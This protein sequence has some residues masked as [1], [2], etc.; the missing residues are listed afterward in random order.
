MNTTPDALKEF[1]RLAKAATQGNWARSGVRDKRRMQ[2]EDCIVLL[3][4]DAGVGYF[5][6]GRNG[7]QHHEA[8]NDVAFIAWCFNHRD[9][10]SRALSRPAGGES[11]REKFEAVMRS[12]G[13]TDSTF[14]RDKTGGYLF[15]YMQIRWETWQAARSTASAGDARR[16]EWFS[17]GVSDKMR[18]AAPQAPS[19]ASAGD[20][21]RG[22][23]HIADNL[24]S[25]LGSS[26]TAGG[27]G[28]GM[29]ADHA[30]A[31]QFADIAVAWIENEI[32]KAPATATAPEGWVMVPREPTVDMV[33]RGREQLSQGDAKVQTHARVLW[34]WE[35]MLQ[36]AP[37]APSSPMAG[38]GLTEEER[39]TV[40]KALNLIEGLL[41]TPASDYEINKAREFAIGIRRKL[42]RLIPHTG[43]SG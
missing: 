8:F 39:E 14:E 10:I 33:E 29:R 22:M 24:K 28:S 13:M 32:A 34:V 42:D 15:D 7:A 17:D 20:Y 23:Q 35:A 6:T 38:V 26:A 18:S 21:V 12:K 2:G 1:E 31:L 30:A 40:I 37:R 9:L 43:R 16:E 36:A 3:L 11:E 41:I 5:P 27:V 25:A 4:N 19:T